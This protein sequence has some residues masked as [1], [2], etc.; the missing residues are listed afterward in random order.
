MPDDAIYK[1]PPAKDNPALP[2]EQPNRPGFATGTNDERP[3]ELEQR[4][5]Q[6][7]NQEDLTGKGQETDRP[8]ALP[9]E[10]EGPLGEGGQLRGPDAGG[11]GSS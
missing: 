1:M 6:L 2:D 11:G 9:G 7:E 10:N 4:M 8:Y 5:Q 3:P